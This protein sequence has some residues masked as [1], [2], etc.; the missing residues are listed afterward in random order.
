MNS[1]QLLDAIGKLDE[2]FYINCEAYQSPKRGKTV[3]KRVAIVTFALLG[4]F[5]LSYLT[6]PTVRAFFQHSPMQ[7]PPH[8]IQLPPELTTWSEITSN[9]GCISHVGILR[10][11]TLYLL[12]QEEYHKIK[13]DGADPDEVL[14]ERENWAAEW[15]DYTAPA[16]DEQPPQDGV[17]VME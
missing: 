10:G 7:E 12:T 13:D 1:R 3:I 8:Y 6:I 2:S 5:Y 9:G 14:A 15:K 4:L 11:D 16:L 17:L